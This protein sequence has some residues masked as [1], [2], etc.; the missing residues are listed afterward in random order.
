MASQDSDQNKNTLDNSQQGTG[1]NTQETQDSGPSQGQ[2][3]NSQVGYYNE[4]ERAGNY[5][6]YNYGRNPAPNFN[7]M[8]RVEGVY[9]VPCKSVRVFQREN[10]YEM[11]QEGGLNDYV[12]MRRKPISRPFTFQIERYVGTDTIDPLNNGAALIL[13]ILLI[14]TRHLV[15]EEAT[16]IRIYAF[17]GCTVTAKEYGELNAER[18]GLLTETTTIAYRE[19]LSLD[20]VAQSF[21]EVKEW[22]FNGTD[23]KGSGPLR[24]RHDYSWDQ[25]DAAKKELAPKAEKNMWRFDGQ[26]RAGSGK[27]SAKQSDVDG[28]YSKEKAAESAEKKMW[29]FD[30]QS[31]AGSGKQSAMQSDVDMEYSKKKA[32]ASA[33]ENMWRFDGQSRDGKGKRSAAQ[34]TGDPDYSLSR[35]KAAAE[36][37]RWSSSHNVR[38][39][40]D[41]AKFLAD[42]RKAG[43]GTQSASF[44]RK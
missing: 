9:D 17:T 42:K 10:E 6:V 21:M 15:Y 31:R 22:K 4:D 1:S 16:A 36:A 29:H 43:S 3:Y 18:S 5:L 2:I 44:T 27:Q 19:M 41:V 7:F 39:A 32:A 14:I 33:E 26:S 12:H 24:A 38:N 34:G 25:A 11:I 28:T 20:N 40:V 35:A 37:N 30:G 13:P 23:K 8:L